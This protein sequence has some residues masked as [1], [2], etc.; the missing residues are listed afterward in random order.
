MNLKYCFL[1]LFLFQ[2]GTLV[3][4]EPIDKLLSKYNSHSIPYISVEE[5]KMQT[6][7]E[8]VFVLDSR[9]LEEFEVSHLKNSTFVGYN[10]FSVANVVSKIKNKNAPIVVY[11]SL[12]IR[13]ETISEKLKNAGYTNIKNLYGGIFEWKNKGYSVY[14]SSNKETQKIHA[15]SKHWSKYLH[16]GEKV[17]KL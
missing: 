13:S 1:L 17:Y 11:C 5:L 9:E 16:K 2:L 8:K 6:E 4:Q 10:N 14:D 7:N 3:A 12:G 15:F